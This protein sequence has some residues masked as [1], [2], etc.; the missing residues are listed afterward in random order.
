MRRRSRRASR[1]CGRSGG[2][3]R[4][5]CSGRAVEGS[6]TRGRTSRERGA[7][8]PAQSA[9]PRG[10]GPLVDPVDALGERA[11]AGGGDAADRR[12]RARLSSR[13]SARWW[14]PL[15]W[16]AFQAARA[17]ARSARR[18]QCRALVREARVADH[19]WVLGKICA[20]G[21]GRARRPPPRVASG[22]RRRPGI[23]RDTARERAFGGDGR[24][25]VPAARR[26]PTLRLIGCASASN[27]GGGIAFS[28]SSSD[29]ELTRRSRMRPRS[30]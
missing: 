29:V 24:R 16:P 28:S 6:L 9:P 27:G 14:R 25:P 1:P 7:R 3:R 21:G 8:A 12:T 20:C 30:R 22:R 17:L 5:L 15:R 4:T 13:W 2:S 23:D 26:R 19:R 10:G 11:D 18:P